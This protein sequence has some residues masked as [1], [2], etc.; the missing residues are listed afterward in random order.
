TYGH[1]IADNGGRA[2]GSASTP[3]RSVGRHVIVAVT[4]VEAGV[5]ELEV[6]GT[7][8]NRTD[9]ALDWG[10]DGIEVDLDASE[11]SSPLYVIE[12][13]AEN[14]IQLKTL[15]DLSGVEGNELIGTHTF[16]S[17]SESNGAS[18]DFSGDKVFVIE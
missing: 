8:W 13:N 7:P 12:L 11:D 5:W 17:L 9:L 2:A 4:Q 3:I 16:Q 15:T 6:G 1:L 18:L 10:I 14:S